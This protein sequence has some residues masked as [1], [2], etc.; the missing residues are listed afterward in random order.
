[1]DWLRQYRPD[2]VPR[3]ERLYEEGGY[4]P[5]GERARVQRMIRRGRRLNPA[6]GSP[7]SRGAAA[8]PRRAVIEEPDP[9]PRPAT[10]KPQRLF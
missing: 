5:K 1:M 3:Y 10:A 8:R 6:S 4:L 2:L 7:P 9:D